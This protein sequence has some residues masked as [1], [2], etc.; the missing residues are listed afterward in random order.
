MA[1]LLSVSTR[2]S[3]MRSNKLKVAENKTHKVKSD[4]KNKSNNFLLMFKLILFKVNYFILTKDY[5][6]VPFDN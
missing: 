2:S 4:S 1:I 3:F 5:E 6:F